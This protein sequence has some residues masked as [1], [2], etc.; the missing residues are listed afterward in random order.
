MADPELEGQ[1]WLKIL[2][3]RSPRAVLDEGSGP[4]PPR[5]SK[6]HGIQAPGKC[7][8]PSPPYGGLKIVTKWLPRAVLD[9]GS[10]PGPPKASKDHGIQAPGKYP[11]PRRAENRHEMASQGR[12]G[13]RF[14][15]R[16]S[17]SL[18]GP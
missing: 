12:S 2:T 15:A 10:G 3:K 11:S 4:G 8:P 17:E 6:D 1:T 5:A 18:E 16:A 7:H 14:R 13:R 9:E